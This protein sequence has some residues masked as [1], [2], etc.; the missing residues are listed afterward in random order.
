[1]SSIIT[2]PETSSE[3]PNFDNYP[4]LRENWNYSYSKLQELN[5][6]LNKSFNGSTDFSIITAGS[7]GRMEASKESDLDFIILFADGSTD[8]GDKIREK[9]NSILDEL[10]IEK[11]NPNG[12]FSK[13][14]SSKTLVEDIGAKTDMADSLTQR[15]LLLMESRPLYNQ[16]LYN[17]IIGELLD[18]YLDLVKNHPHKEA[19]FLM[20]DLIRYFRSIAV[21]YQNTF[22]REGE[23]WTLRNV[24]LRH[25]R[26]LIYAGLL[27]PILNASKNQTDK[28]GYLLKFMKLTPMERV[29]NVYRDNSDN[30]FGK[31]LNIYDVFLFKLNVKETR[32]NLKVDYEQRYSN[33]VY[34]ELKINSDSFMSELTRFV[35][36]QRGKWTE[37]AF[38]YLIF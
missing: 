5:S 10:E 26:V 22:W 9:V 16:D 12:A 17:R 15:M 11:P 13:T 7:Y 19:V 6:L 24:K 25:S 8:E 34:K 31:L 18:K 36:A 29:V 4:S 14:Q 32:E 28:Y 37:H 27:L 2:Y 38:E 3:I 35:F 21:N 1:M 33:P 23:K 20:N 30:N